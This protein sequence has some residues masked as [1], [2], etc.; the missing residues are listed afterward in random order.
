[1]SDISPG[2]CLTP[3]PPSPGGENAQRRTVRPK[4]QSSRSE[5]ALKRANDPS[6]VHWN[7]PSGHSSPK[8]SEKKRSL[9]RKG[10]AESLNSDPEKLQ[11]S[12][13]SSTFKRLVQF[14]RHCITP[15]ARKEEPSVG[16]A[17]DGFQWKHELSGRWIEI[18][19]APK[20][21]G[22]G[23]QKAADGPNVEMQ[24]SSRGTQMSNG[25]PPQRSPKPVEYLG[26]PHNSLATSEK[27][28]LL[29]VAIR[30]LSRSAP[31]SPGPRAKRAMPR[32]Y[33]PGPQ[34]GLEYS[35]RPD[36][37]RTRSTT[38]MLLERVASILKDVAPRKTS[39]K[40]GASSQSG[41]CSNAAS[42][43]HS[44]RL[45][46]LCQG[47]SNTSFHSDWPTSKPPLATPASADSQLMYL[48]PDDKQY[49]RVEISEPGGPTYLPSEARRIG[50]PPLLGQGGR[51]RGF[52][53]DYT[54]AQT[55]SDKVDA[56]LSPTQVRRKKSSEIDWYSAK[57]AAEEKQ[58]AMG[59]FEL[60]VTDHLPSSPLCPRN[61]KHKSGGRGVCVYHG[62]NR[63]LQEAL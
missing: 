5:S 46:P 43:S 61:P 27:R 11:Q 57:I 12:P 56:G 24:V 47:N 59:T 41:N 36:T 52:F 20:S 38:G 29:A 40:S 53:F 35:R 3:L 14:S 23:S 54:L 31:E 6:F 1:M 28:N 37:L 9:F 50:T 13:G 49:F 19:V 16:K 51:P 21:P 32:K 33:L 7:P 22:Q 55:G 45:T 2:T 15:P 42:Y 60:N 4:H 30:E 58:D 26:T 17:N 8:I 10:S 18:K 44:L 34:L 25:T 48:G 39:P 62:R 63:E